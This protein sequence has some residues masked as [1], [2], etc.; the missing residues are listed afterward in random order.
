MLPCGCLT[1]ESQCEL[2]FV[3]GFRVHHGEPLVQAYNNGRR[4]VKRREGTRPHV[5]V[6]KAVPRPAIQAISPL[7]LL[8]TT[9]TEGRRE[10]LPVSCYEH[11]IGSYALA[12]HD[13]INPSR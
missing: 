1:L 13:Q 4:I 8:V 12:A 9:A 7:A 2:Y 10:D 6:Y 5:V 11:R 3:Q